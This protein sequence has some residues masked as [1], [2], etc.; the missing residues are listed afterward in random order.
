M[1]T[2][3]KPKQRLHRDFVYLQHDTILTKAKV[4]KW[5]VQAVM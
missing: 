4:S 1:G 2:Y 5:T 3:K